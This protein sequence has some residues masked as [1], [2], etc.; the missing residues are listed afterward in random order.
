M[1]PFRQPFDYATSRGPSPNRCGPLIGSRIRLAG[2]RRE[3]LTRPMRVTKFEHATLTIVDS[4]RTLV[5]DPGSFTA[6][7]GELED[8]VGIVITHE[9]ADHWT[10]GHLDRLTQ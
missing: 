7:L 2:A 8:V 9:H 10:A 1:G 4:G 5:I 3:R 6:P